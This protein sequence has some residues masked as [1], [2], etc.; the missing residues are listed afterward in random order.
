[1]PAVEAAGRNPVV[2]VIVLDRKPDTVALRDLGAGADVTS[3]ELLLTVAPK[4]RA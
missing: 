3:L 2:P 1:M 4:S